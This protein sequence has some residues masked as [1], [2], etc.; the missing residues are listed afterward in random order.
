MCFGR[1]LNQE[2]Q[3]LLVKKTRDGPTDGL[4]NGPTDR[5]MDGPTDRPSMLD[6]IS[7]EYFQRLRQI[8][9]TLTRFLNPKQS[10]LWLQKGEL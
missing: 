1:D 3:I 9:E 4:T 10:K 2:H 7:V 6:K 5:P 8:G